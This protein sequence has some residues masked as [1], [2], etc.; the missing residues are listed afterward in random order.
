MAF[1]EAVGDMLTDDG[2]V[3]LVDESPHDLWAE[4]AP[5]SEGPSDPDDREV[6]I[7]TLNDGRRFR[8]VKVLWDPPELATRLAELGWQATFTREDPF[9]WGTVRRRASAR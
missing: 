5:V 8:I 1:W 2:R 9:F 4:E 7:R 3:F 6:V